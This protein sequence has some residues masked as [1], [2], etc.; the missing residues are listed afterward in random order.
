M[1]TFGTFT[2]LITVPCSGHKPQEPAGV[3]ILQRALAANLHDNAQFAL[4]LSGLKENRQSERTEVFEKLMD[5]FEYFSN[6]LDIPCQ[7]KSRIL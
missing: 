4:V 6:A 2:T 7:Y 3:G 1:G 5:M